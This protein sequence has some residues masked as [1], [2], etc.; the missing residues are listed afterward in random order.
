MAQSKVEAL[1]SENESFKKQIYALL[2]EVK[3]DKDCL[4]TLEKCIDTKKAFYK[5]KDKQIDETLQKI[6]KAGSKAVDKFKASNKYSDKLYDY[7]V[8]GF[9]LF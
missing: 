2:E 4:K 6:E 5:L 9:N 3:V 7:Y 8:E 1:S